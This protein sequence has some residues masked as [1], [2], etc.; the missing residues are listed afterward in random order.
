MFGTERRYAMAK[1]GRPRFNDRA[2]FSFF[3]ARNVYQKGRQL[4]SFSR[5]MNHENICRSYFEVDLPAKGIS[6]LGPGV[7]CAKAKSK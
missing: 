5:H 6:D 7:Y 2:W 3:G 1:A 4:Q